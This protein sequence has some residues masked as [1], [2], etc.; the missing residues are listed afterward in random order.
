MLRR[1]LTTALLAAAAAVTLTACSTTSSFHSTWQN[2]AA[3]TL[4]LRGRK[5]AAL[6]LHENEALR[7]AAE[8]ALAREITVHGAVGVPAYTLLPREA[9]HDKDKAKLLLEQAQVEGVVAM[10]A[11]AWNKALLPNLGTSWGSPQCG[12]FW[13]PEFWSWS[14]DYD[15]SLRPD[16][17][18]IVE[19][20][21]YSL[22][23]N[24]LVWASQSQTT[25]PLKV[26]PVIHELS[27]RIGAEMEKQ[28]L[29]GD[30]ASVAAVGF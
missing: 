26:G 2:P 8:D 1:T 23:Q 12:S 30:S 22:S 7:C 3:E 14:G 27:R 24:K 17:V 20:L 13:G 5:V 6:V 16:T 4:D 29:L 9:V 28:G 19:T 25:N 10:R 18:L 15:G 21:V 11:V